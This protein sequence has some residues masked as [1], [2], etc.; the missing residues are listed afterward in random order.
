MR[1]CARAA[2]AAFAAN[3]LNAK[4]RGDAER[5]TT[6]TKSS[7]AALLSKRY[8]FVPSKLERA[9]TGSTNTSSGVES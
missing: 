9:K 8:P 6:F 4:I 1:V 3:K 7:V 2:A 5:Y